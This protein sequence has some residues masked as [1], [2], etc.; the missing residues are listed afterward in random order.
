MVHRYHEQCHIKIGREYVAL[1]RKVR[2]LADNI[3]LSVFDFSDKGCTI[4]VI[5]KH[6]TRSPT[7]HRRC[8]A[9]AFKS[10]IA[11]YFAFHNTAVV[12]F[13]RVPTAP[14][15]LLP[16]LA[17][18]AL[19]A[20]LNRHYLLVLSLKQVINLFNKLV[21]QLLELFFSVFFVVF[22]TVRL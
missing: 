17:C 4:L 21:V 7:R 5:Y 13:H 3:I 9:Y 2:R 8:A 1:L 6:G 15:S 10:K 16:V 11:F 12:G 22:P 18:C 14:C 20:A 19:G